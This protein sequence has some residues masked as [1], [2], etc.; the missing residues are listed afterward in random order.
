MR[1]VL[2]SPMGDN[3]I[4]YTESLDV[5]TAWLRDLVPEMVSNSANLPPWQMQL[6]PTNRAEQE[7]MGKHVE[8]TLDEAGLLMLSELFRCAAMSYRAAR[9]GREI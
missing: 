1:V 3:R 8:P 2:Q 6:W 7:A 5:L 4:I 9:T